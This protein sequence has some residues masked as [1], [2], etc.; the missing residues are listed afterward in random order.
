MTRLAFFLSKSAR[1]LWVRPTIFSLGAIGWVALSYFG[2]TLVPAANRVDISRETL[3]SLFSI[4]AST[5][6]TVAT[7]SVSAI[8]SA[9]N[10]VATSATPRATSIVMGDARIQSTLAAFLAAFI[11]AVVSITALS[12]VPF[13]P[14]G[15]FLLFVG[16]VILV[17]WVLMS[18]LG[19]VDRVSRL[20][21]L[22]DTLGRVTTA[23]RKAFSDP[24][25]AGAL[26]GRHHSEGSRPEDGHIVRSECFG[27]VQH[28]DLEK[29]QD[30]A[31]EWEADVWMEVRPGAL[32]AARSPI[33]VIRSNKALDDEASKRVRDCLTTGSDRSYETDP[34]YSMI[35]LAEVAGRALSPAVN[36]PGTAISV[37]AI[38]LELFHAWAENHGKRT[39]DCPFDRVWVPEITARDLVFDALTPLAR[40]GAGMIEVGL[41]LQK[42]LRALRQMDN[43]ELRDAAEEFRDTALELSDR[44]L[45]IASQREAVRKCAE[46]PLEAVIP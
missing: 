5:M 40:D 15:R 17:G 12:A 2:S 28:I 19:W 22:G 16:F 10:S 25:I 45:P 32:L 37:I 4:L 29:L 13:G 35:L 18:F 30:L 33:A 1:R 9:F 34:R 14:A 21:M 46:R 23:A 27:Y 42:G 20:G 31:E 3:I 38:Q 39:A 8:S 36:D 24:E 43:K 41:R 26:G 11:Y 44:A 7:F 6:L